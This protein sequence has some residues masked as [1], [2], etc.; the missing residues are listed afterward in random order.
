[1]TQPSV[2]QVFRAAIAANFGGGEEPPGIDPSWQQRT[3]DELA[4]VF[5]PA[6]VPE[7]LERTRSWL[8][9]DPKVSR[10]LAL[11]GWGNHPGVVRFLVAEALQIKA[12][13]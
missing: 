5:G 13:P 11:A 4:S 12:L 7:V 8:A 10:L 9:T 6:K 2:E 3:L 1:M